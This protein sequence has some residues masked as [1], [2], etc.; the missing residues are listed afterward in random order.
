MSTTL[1]V[2][3]LFFVHASLVLIMRPFELRTSTQDAQELINEA[4]DKSDESLKR[5]LQGS[6]SDLGE[7]GRC[8]ETLRELDLLLEKYTIA[9]PKIGKLSMSNWKAKSRQWFRP[10]TDADIGKFTLKLGA[11]CERLSLNI[12][13]D[14]K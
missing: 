7:I 1:E 4:D 3:F 12:G 8:H 2:F 9:D 13:V 10:I 11:H 5:M 14:S 6:G